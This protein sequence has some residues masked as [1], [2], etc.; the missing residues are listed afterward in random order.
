MENKIKQILEELYRV[1]ASLRGREEELIKAIEKIVVLKDSIVPDAEFIRSLKSKLDLEIDKASISK[2]PVFPGL[3][4]M[5]KYTYSLGG[6]ALAVIV[7]VV[8]YNSL[9]V[10][11]EEPYLSS[12]SKIAIA[13]VSDRAFGGGGGA[14]S[15][16][17]AISTSARPQSGGGGAP[18]IDSKMIAP[19][20]YYPTQYTYVYKG[21]AI[22]LNDSKVNVLKRITGSAI[23]GQLNTLVSRINFDFLDMK[24]FSGLYI[25]NL[26]LAE[27]KEYGHAISVNSIDNSVSIYENWE[28][29][30]GAYP[31]CRDDGCSN[32]RQLTQS[33]VPADAELV[34]IANSF[35]GEKGIDISGYGNPEINKNWG[36]PMPLGAAETMMAPS[37]PTYIP[38][39]IQVTYPLLID[40][41]KVYEGS[42]AV[43]LYVNINIRVNK[44]SSVI[45]LGVN[46]YESSAYEA[47][48][49]FNKILEI[50]KNGGQ[51]GYYPAY[52][53]GYGEVP[54]TIE[55]QLGTPTFEYVRI[56]KYDEGKQTPTELIAPALIFPILGQQNSYQSFITVPLVKELLNQYNTPGIMPMMPKG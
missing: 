40:G 35:L 28:K 34:N 23:A 33:D 48:Q 1:D 20:P 51:W 18:S 50:A 3:N 26:V 32:I 12:G 54:R 49:D 13:P 38:D 4:F 53:T 55:V 45:G 7:L 21:E 9:N 25:Q 22:E 17:M 11:R 19:Y 56:W 42:Q 5:N 39:S 44:V 52:D 36:G 8:G 16:E 27:N 30:T 31:I 29:W 37:M 6:I 43:G 46:S 15:S 24:K 2:V 14:A 47:E 41:K 10:T